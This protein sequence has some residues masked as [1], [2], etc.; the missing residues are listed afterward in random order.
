MSGP[1]LLDVYTTGADGNRRSEF[2]P[3]DLFQFN[4]AHTLSDDLPLGTGVIVHW[5]VERYEEMGFENEPSVLNGTSNIPITMVCVMR[6]L[7]HRQ[8]TYQW[9]SQIDWM[10]FTL[11]DL[12]DPSVP[13]VGLDQAGLV[14]Y[15]KNDW[16][17]LSQ[18]GLWKLTS[19]VELEFNPDTPI[20]GDAS[21]NY[22]ILLASNV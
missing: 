18:P 11:P 3:T 14:D 6:R 1:T 16:G 9:R 22:R 12:P 7:F 5:I 21:W 13:V 10:N 19:L 4:T 8:T 17:I 20:A 15:V 2:R